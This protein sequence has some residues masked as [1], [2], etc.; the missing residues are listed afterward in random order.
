MIIKKSEI[1]LVPANELTRNPVS[2]FNFDAVDAEMLTNVMF[3]RMSEMG[4]VALSAPQV[5]LDMSMFVMGI[6]DAKI[7]VFNPKIISSSIKTELMNEGSLTFPGILV[8][9]KRPVSIEVE[10]YNKKGE[11]QQNE[12]HGLTARIFQHAYDHLK[13]RTIKEKVSVLKWKMA[14]KRLDNYKQKLVKKYTQ[15]TLFD[16]KKAMEEQTNGN[17]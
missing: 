7:E 4:G 1:K 16:I 12:F 6:N 5:G 13:G 10:Y 14:V 2:E 15:K 8:I 9:V 3:D 17:T 11:L